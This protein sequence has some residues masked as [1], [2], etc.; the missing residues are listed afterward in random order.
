M[1]PLVLMLIF[2]CACVLGQQTEAD[3]KGHLSVPHE[4]PTVDFCELLGNPDLYHQKVVRTAAIFRYGGED[5]SDLYCPN[6]LGAGWGWVRPLFDESYYSCTRPKLTAKL[7]RQKHGSGSVK[8]VVVGKF[9]EGQG[10]GHSFQ[11]Q[12]V[13]RAEYISKDYQIPGVAQA[14]KVRRIRCP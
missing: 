5:T 4:V 3:R 11:I 6:C 14:P 9:I 7:S 8:V 2:S 13:E 10:G 12:C 1:R